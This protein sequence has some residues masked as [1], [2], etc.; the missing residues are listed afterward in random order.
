MLT[1]FFL[2][3]IE[4]MIQLSP[5]SFAVFVESGLVIILFHLLHESNQSEPHKRMCT[6][7]FHVLNS[8][9]SCWE[10]VTHHTQTTIEALWSE[11]LSHNHTHALSLH[12]VCEFPKWLSVVVPLFQQASSIS[13]IKHHH[14]LYESIV[15]F[16]I[17]ISNHPATKR[18]SLLF[19]F[20]CCCS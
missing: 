10:K 7:I 19:S 5:I 9:I 12:P 1:F 4:S 20:C 18:V 14:L 2:C 15:D 3:Y 13:S 8:L 6:S 11:Y 17:R 16:F